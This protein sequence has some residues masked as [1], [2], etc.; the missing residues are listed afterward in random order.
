MKRELDDLGLPKNREV[1]FSQASRL[2]GIFYQEEF[3]LRFPK[4]KRNW[5]GIAL[6]VCLGIVTAI[7]VYFAI[8]L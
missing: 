6:T 7:T 2:G 8:T 3:P 5:K 4:K 1:D